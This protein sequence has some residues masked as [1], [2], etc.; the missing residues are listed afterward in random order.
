MG[1]GSTLEPREHHPSPVQ[2]GRRRQGLIPLACDQRKPI[3]RG[4]DSRHDRGRDDADRSVESSCR[5]HPGSL[6]GPECFMPIPERFVS[7][8][9]FFRI[10]LPPYGPAVGFVITTAIIREAAYAGGRHISA[11]GIFRWNPKP[12]WRPA[13]RAG[14]NAVEATSR[15]APA[16]S[17]ARRRGLAPGRAI[18]QRPAGRPGQRPGQRPKQ[19]SRPTPGRPGRLPRDQRSRL[20]CRS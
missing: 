2:P 16:N 17:G 3:G 10:P 6:A 19:R 1:H 14:I 15:P 8:G 9:W 11:A 12:G 18:G 7:H 5:C 13:R 4:V 20:R